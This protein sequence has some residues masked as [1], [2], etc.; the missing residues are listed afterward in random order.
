MLYTYCMTDQEIRD[1]LRTFIKDEIILGPST[2]NIFKLK[3][4]YR[5][6]IIIKY[7]VLDNIKV[8]LIK[9]NNRFFNDKKV[10]F[11]VDFNP[12]KM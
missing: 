9:L 7:K 8:P 11:D 4:E 5:F 6:N 1:Y 3:G 2:C 12:V 10:K